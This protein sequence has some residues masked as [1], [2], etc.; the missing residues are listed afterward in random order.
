MSAGRVEHPS[1]YLPLRAVVR[2]GLMPFITRT[3]VT[4]TE[5]V[6]RTGP[7]FLVPN[8][9]SLLDPL[10]IQSVCPRIVH[11]MTK[12]TQFS[13]PLM[14]WLL[15]RIGSF[16]TRRY[17][18]DPQAVRVALRELERGRGV[19]I[20]PEGE[21]SW[22]GQ[23][24]PLRKGT[25]RLLLKA[26]VPI[27]PCGISGS[28]DVWPRWSKRPRRCRVRVRFGPPIEFGRHDDR[29]EREAALPGATLTLER[30]LRTLTDSVDREWEHQEEH[31]ERG[32]GPETL[33]SWA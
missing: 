7:F 5:H 15:P 26:G 2:W 24:Q 28:Y 30:A 21:R 3:R 13:S 33:E 6:P 12:S 17:R 32:V 10:V 1:L 25:M 20:Y 31:E 11:S 8:H 27:V 18:V 29:A 16:P 19:G 4:G 23:L 14:R 9:Q 22:D